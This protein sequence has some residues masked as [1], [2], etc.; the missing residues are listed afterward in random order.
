ML[1][2]EPPRSQG[3]V[4]FRLFDFP[5]RIHPF[6]WVAVL[7]LGYRP[8]GTAPL[9][10]VVW[11]AVVIVSI[12]VHELGHAVLQRR[13]NGRPR[14]VLYGFGGLAITDYIDFAP[15]RQIAIS[16]AGPAAGLCLAV[17]TLALL[18][19]SGHGVGVQLGSRFRFEGSGLE[20]AY[21]LPLLL[22]NIYWAP[23]KQPLADLVAANLLTVNIYWSL[24]NLLPI[25]PLDGGRVSREL[26]LVKNQSGGIE[27][28]LKLSLAAAAVVVL[29][30]LVHSQLF[31]AL[32]LGYLGY[33]NY[34]TLRRYQGARW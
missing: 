4:H 15:R 14:I 18:W 9:E 2:A 3:D 8:D 30:A 28:S 6:F 12:L 5:I 10:L 20:A 16:L 27:Q 11:V 22:L 23:P 21:S 13:Y 17:A 26:F 25:Y 32:M 7:L 29:Y 33:A 19:V 34:Q 31:L 1:L 24:L